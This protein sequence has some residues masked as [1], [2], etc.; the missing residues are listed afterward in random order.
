MVKYIGITMEYRKD[1]YGNDVS[2]LGYGCMRFSKKAGIIDL[3]K[4]EKEVLRA[5]ELGINYFD[6]A[7][8]YGGSEETLG[9]IFTRNPGLRDKVKIATK[10]PQYMIRNREQIDKIFEEELRRLETDHIDY[11][12]MHMFTD[13]AGW[14]NIKKLGIEDWIKEKKASGQIKQIGFSFHGNTEMFL[15]ILDVYDWDFCQ[16]QYNYLDEVS[17]AGRKGLMAAAAKNIPVIIMEPLRGGKLVNMLPQ[18]A[19][20]AIA[21]NPTKRSPAEWAFRWLWDQKEVTVVLSGMNSMEML[22]ENARIASQ[23]KVGEFTQT[24]FDMITEIKNAINENT[25]VGCTGCAYCMP[26]PKGVDIPSAFFYLNQT[27]ISGTWKT[28]AE[29]GQV[30]GLR[31]DPSLPGQCIQC[32]KCE[33]H[34]PQSIPIRDMLKKAN[35]VL[36]PPPV[37]LVLNVARK[38]ALSGRSK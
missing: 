37:K 23:V 35:K 15:K 29:Y 5:V 26:C 14:E 7:Y 30:V 31:K 9:K 25:I 18:K 4:T 2:I 33:K 36:T 27:K 34:C 12:L 10:L 8:I 22:E 19:L 20:T 3:E 32:G 6:T 38:F 21:N 28:R 16:I 24:D 1:K 13:I 11:Y 17:Q